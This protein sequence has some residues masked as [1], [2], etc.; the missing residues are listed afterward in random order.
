[1]AS[2]ACESQS[3]RTYL[4]ACALNIFESNNGGFLLKLSQHLKSSLIKFSDFG[5]LLKFQKRKKNA[6]EVSSSGGGG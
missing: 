3:K 6:E 4:Q 2:L 5:N 1:M